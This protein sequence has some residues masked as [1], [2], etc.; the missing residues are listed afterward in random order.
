MSRVYLSCLLFSLLQ[1]LAVPLAAQSSTRSITVT[2]VAEK[3]LAPDRYTIS[4]AIQAEG[5]WMKMIR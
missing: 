4:V 5:T 1:L 3:E 2:G